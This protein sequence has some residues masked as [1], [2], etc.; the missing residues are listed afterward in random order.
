MP[1]PPSFP[2]IGV[3]DFVTADLLTSMLP[4]QV[5]K[6]N[7]TSRASTSTVTA[8]PDLSGIT[9]GIG[10]YEIEMFILWSQTS[11]ATQRLQTQWGFSG[12]WN[13]PTR[14]C[15]GP[16]DVVTGPA[17][18]AVTETNFSGN[19]ANVSANYNVQNNSSPTI[20]REFSATVTV[21]TAGDFSLLWAQGAGT[22][23]ANTVIVQVGSYV[24]IR[25]IG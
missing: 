18:T 22:T 14:V 10:T 13:N 7:S 1:V 16:G 15:N 11:T 4:S 3:G 8:D 12:S 6:L 20:V 19:V 21:S 2:V 24:R 17:R 9:L 23:S 5:T 25:Q